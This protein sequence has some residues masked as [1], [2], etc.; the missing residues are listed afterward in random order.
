MV[1][2]TVQNIFDLCGNRHGRENGCYMAEV[3]HIREHLLI[4]SQK[5]TCIYLQ[6]SLRNIY[7]SV[8]TRIKVDDIIR[9]IT[10]EKTLRNWKFRNIRN[11]NLPR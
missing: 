10:R 6:Q 8:E 4:N 2:V 9:D 7:I 5:E 11:V 3:W 1:L